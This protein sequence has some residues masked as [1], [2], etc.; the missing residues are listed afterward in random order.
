MHNALTMILFRA[1]K[2]GPEE[3]GV[4]SEWRAKGTGKTVVELLRCDFLSSEGM[5][6][7]ATRLEMYDLTGPLVSPLLKS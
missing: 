5:G 3:V 4:M 6:R 2:G 7:V 1:P